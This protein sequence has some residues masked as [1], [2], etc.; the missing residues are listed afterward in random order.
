MMAWRSLQALQ[1]GTLA[2]MFP[3]MDRSLGMGMGGPGGQVGRAGQHGLWLA[4]A[5][6]QAQQAENMMRLQQ[7]Q[8]QQ[9]VTSGTWHLVS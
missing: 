3:P 8:Q 2:D 4:M 9:Q 5:Q 6:A 7:Q 1:G